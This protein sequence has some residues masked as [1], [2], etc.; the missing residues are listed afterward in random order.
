ML[1]LLNSDNKIEKDLMKDM[2][3]WTLKGDM[4][5]QTLADTQG[6]N[7]EEPDKNNKMRKEDGISVHP[8]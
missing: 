2:Q 7:I 1:D 3:A 5:T 8:Y 6:T 4:D